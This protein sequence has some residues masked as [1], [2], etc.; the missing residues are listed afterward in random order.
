MY[1]ALNTP[2]KSIRTN[3][4]RKVAEYNIEKKGAFLYIL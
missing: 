4:F 1:K 2:P 3:K